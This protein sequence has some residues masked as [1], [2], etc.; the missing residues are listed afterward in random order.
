MGADSSAPICQIKSGVQNEK[1]CFY[2]YGIGNNGFMF[3]SM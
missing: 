3:Y 2:T 1:N